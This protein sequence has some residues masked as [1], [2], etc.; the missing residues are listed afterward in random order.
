M[1][2]EGQLARKKT[3]AKPVRIFEDNIKTNL[4]EV[5]QENVEWIDL[6]QD[7]DKWRAVEHGSEIW[8]A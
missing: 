3:L 4:K 8:V 6:A 7:M 2:W 5:K 1:F